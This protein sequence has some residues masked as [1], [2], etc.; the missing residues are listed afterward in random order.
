V[1]T[2]VALAAALAALACRREAP[3]EPHPAPRPAPE[4]FRMADLA[5]ATAFDAKVARLSLLAATYQSWLQVRPDDLRARTDALAPRLE[6]AAR[7]VERALAPIRNASDRVLAA[8]LAAAVL[9]WPALL[10][11]ARDE[12][13]SGDRSRMAAGEALAAADGTIGAALLE[14]RRFRSGWAIGDAPAELPEVVRWLEAR[15]DLERIEGALGERMPADGGVSLARPQGFREAVADA[16]GRARTGAAA[17][18]EARRGH[19]LA[20]IDAQE[21]AVG[22]MLDLAGAVAPAARARAAL[23]YQSEK[24]AVLEAVAEYTRLT[25][26]RAAAR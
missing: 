16:A 1:K 24:V 21:R 4:T 18:D 15:R 13:L 12:A 3:E 23:A 10:A 19:A 25:A 26:A 6:E 22:A 17:L 7:D 2:T 5:A 20:W 8:R 9:R 11:A 14:Y